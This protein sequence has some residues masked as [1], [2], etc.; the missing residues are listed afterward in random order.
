MKRL[1]CFLVL[2]AFLITGCKLGPDYVRPP[3]KAPDGW[4]DHENT[5]K[6]IADLPWWE[7]FNDPTLQGLIKAALAE[8]RDTAAALERV[9]EAKAL[10]GIT[11]ADYYPTVTGSATAGGVNPSNETLQL[12]DNF[13]NLKSGTQGYYALSADVSW[14]IDLFGRVRRANEAQRAV[15]LGTEEAY[16]S[17]VILLVSE[18]ARVYYDLRGLD[19][20]VEIGHQTLQSRQEYVDLAKHRFEGGVTPELDWRQAE[21][22]YYRT[23]AVVYELEKQVRIAENAMSVLLGRPPGEIP[24]GLNI[25][26]EHTLPEIPAG[27]PSQLLERRPDILAAEQQLVAENARIGEAKALMF[28][29]ISLTGSYGVVSRDLDTLISSNAQTWTI[30]PSLFQTI[31]D[32]G[33]NKNRV[34]AQESRQR[35]AILN[36]QQTILISFQDVE[37]ALVSYNKSSE[38]RVSQSARVEALKKVLF[39]SEARYRGG[40]AAYLEVLDAQ[41]SLFDAE[42]NEIDTIRDHTT[43]LV[44]LYKSLGGGWPKITE[45]AHQ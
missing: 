10:L 42:L 28:P 43:S 35:Q 14:E 7:L 38:Q 40:V 17:A 9:Q 32:A 22:E 15:L 19:L 26:D 8:N 18:V 30:I 12:P 4:L 33:R 29:F 11:K 39:L 44:R 34:R 13:P 2:S 3:V 24:R 36:Y 20:E 23:Q 27:L 41:R 6:T 1:I 37:D 21:A 16:R 25:R 45:A 31:F 5:E